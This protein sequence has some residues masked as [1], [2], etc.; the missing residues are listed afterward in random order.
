MRMLAELSHPEGCLF[1]HWSIS[2]IFWCL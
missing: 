1:F 2:R